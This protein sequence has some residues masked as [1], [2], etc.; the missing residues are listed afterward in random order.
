[1]T[2]ADAKPHLKYLIKSLSLVDESVVA[3]R[4]RQLGFIE[5]VELVCEAVA[6]LIKSPILVS[7][8]GMRIVLT[9]QEAMIIE[10]EQAL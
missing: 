3:I 10:V 4:L 7:L 2:L 8:R 9:R 6:P 1:M 5:G